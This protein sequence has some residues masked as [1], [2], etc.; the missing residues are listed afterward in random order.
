MYAR[1]FFSKFELNA[2]ETSTIDL[3]RLEPIGSKI[4][5]SGATA[6]FTCGLIS[7]EDVSFA[8]SKNGHV[9]VQNSPKI[10]I[11]HDRATET[12]TLMLKAASVGDAGNYTCVAKNI[13]SEARESATLTVE[14]LYYLVLDVDAV[15]SYSLS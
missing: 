10:R 11:S 5:Q 4:V 6:R 12:S 15:E 7:G 8:W 13:F 1:R 2:A 14:G 9:V 3:I